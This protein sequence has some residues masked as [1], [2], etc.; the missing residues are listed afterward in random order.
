MHCLNACENAVL[1]FFFGM[2][3][4]STTLYQCAE[5]L[6]EDYD[7]VAVIDACKILGNL[8]LL[9]TCGDSTNYF[10]L[11]PAA[12]GDV[13]NG[14]FRGAGNVSEHMLKL[15]KQLLELQVAQDRIQLES[16]AAAAAR[17]QGAGGVQTQKK[18]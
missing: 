12:M 1:D 17:P 15:E 6:Y 5:K 13:G 11:S 18:K 4:R 14:Y 2:A 16:A 7:N 10:C 9:K 8:G 3:D